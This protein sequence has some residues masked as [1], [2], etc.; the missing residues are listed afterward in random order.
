MSHY[1]Y[2]QLHFE[3][4]YRKLCEVE[5]V[6]VNPAVNDGLIVAHGD[7]CYGYRMEWAEHGL[8]FEHGVAIYLLSY[9]GPWSGEVRET[10]R[11][12]V[13]PVAWVLRNVDRFL[14]YLPPVGPL[15]LG[16]PDEH[17]YQQATAEASSNPQE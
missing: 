17:A 3:A 16:S 2:L 6:P 12:W 15:S 9:I 4:V 10:P 1:D 8:A 11:G 14:P 7:K 5:G 13:A